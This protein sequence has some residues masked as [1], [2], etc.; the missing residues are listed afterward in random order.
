[1]PE[2]STTPDLVELA[3]GA[4][5][6]ANRAIRPPWAASS[7]AGWGRRPYLSAARN[8]IKEETVMRRLIPMVTGL[9]AGAVGGAR[10][11]GGKPTF[12]GQHGERDSDRH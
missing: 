4:V 2:E 5:D 6:A 8:S 10:C 1:M 7:I 3:R 9:A 12:R 11:V